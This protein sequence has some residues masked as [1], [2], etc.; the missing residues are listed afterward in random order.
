MGPEAEP[1]RQWAAW[2][3]ETGGDPPQK[4]VDL[5]LRLTSTPAADRNGEFCWVDDPLQ[6]PI[7]SWDKADRRTTL[8]QRESDRAS[9]R[10]DGQVALV[11]G[12]TRGLGLAIA[13]RLAAEGAAVAVL[14]RDAP[15]AGA[16]AAELVEA[17]GRA[18]AVAADVG[19]WPAAT[20]GD[21]RRRAGA[22]SHR[23]RRHGCGHRRHRHASS[24]PT[25]PTGAA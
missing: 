16:V 8:D 20:R 6:A 24:R 7:H 17:G 19:S 13:E 22:G 23:H 3:E 11:T 15:R 14:G 5:V 9:E 21:R 25:R 1:Y 2:V 10:L 4:A 18:M 12:G